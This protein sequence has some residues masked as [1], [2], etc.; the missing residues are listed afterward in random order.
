MM[1]SDAI[2]IAKGQDLLKAGRFDALTV[3]ELCKRTEKTKGSF[4]HHFGG[5]EAFKKVLLD[6]WEESHT[7]EPMRAGE[8]ESGPKRYDALRRALRN[9]D[10]KL[11]RTMRAWATVDSTARLAC[12][13]IDVQRIAYLADCYPQLTAGE[14]RKQA[15]TEYATL[16]GKMFLFDAKGDA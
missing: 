4:Y 9:L 12:G 1:T 13:R 2:W 7:R 15:R 16:L 6:V 5:I 14:A 10:W 11:E 8:R 3:D